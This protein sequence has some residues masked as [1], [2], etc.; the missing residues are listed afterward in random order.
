M[1][2]QGEKLSNIENQCAFLKIFD[3]ILINEVYEE[4][5]VLVVEYYFNP[6]N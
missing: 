1:I 6:P 4:Y 3:P 5:S 2:E